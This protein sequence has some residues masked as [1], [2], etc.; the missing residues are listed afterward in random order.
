MMTPLERIAVIQAM[1]LTCDDPELM[2]T[3]EALEHEA[4]EKYDAEAAKV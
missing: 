4:M 2:A 1:M 3:L